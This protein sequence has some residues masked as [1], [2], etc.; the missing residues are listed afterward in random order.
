MKR[1][2]NAVWPMTWYGRLLLRNFVG[3][4]YKFNR[5]A[6]YSIVKFFRV[7]SE[8]VRYMSSFVRL[9]SIVCLSSVTF[10][11]RVCNIRPLFQ[12]RIFGYFSRQIRISGFYPFFLQVR[13]GPYIPFSNCKW[14]RRCRPTDENWNAVM[15][16][17]LRDDV[18]C[19]RF[20]IHPQWM[21][22]THWR[23]QSQ[24]K[25]SL[26]QEVGHSDSED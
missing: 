15:P 18:M 6:F 25:D 7:F 3:D 17:R 23:A 19:F 13:I 20:Q 2:S 26:S 9:S 5:A 10:V 22:K 14:H 1:L 12:I 24:R 11:H 21:M 8:R 16:K 4:W